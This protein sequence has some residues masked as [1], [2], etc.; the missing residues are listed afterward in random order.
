MAA[1]RPPVSSAT[2]EEQKQYD[3]YQ[4]GFHI[5]TSSLPWTGKQIVPSLAL[6]WKLAT[7]AWTEHIPQHLYP[8]RG[9]DVTVERDNRGG[10]IPLAMSLST[11]T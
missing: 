10:H 4:D 7:Y 5:I 8:R 6:I 1:S 3:Y 2:T 11:I 9:R